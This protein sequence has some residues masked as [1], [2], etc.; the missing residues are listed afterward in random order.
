[1]GE[2]RIRMTQDF[3]RNSPSVFQFDKHG[4]EVFSVVAAEQNA[5]FNG[6]AVKAD[7]LLFV[8]EDVSSEYRVEEFN[9]LFAAEKADSAGT[10]VIQSSLGYNLFDD[11]NMDYKITDLDGKTA[12]V[13][14]AAAM[15]RD[16]G[17]IVVVSAGNEG[18]NRWRYV[19]PPADADGI[20]A[21]GAVNFE[22]QKAGFSSIGPTADGRIKPDVMALGQSTSVIT[23]NGTL[24]SASGTSLA[25]PLVT[26]LVAGLLQAYPKLRPAEIIQAVKLSASLSAAPNNQMGYGL[27]HYVAVKNYLES[28]QSGDDVYVYPNPT[29]GTLTVAFKKLPESSVALQIFD[30]L[31]KVVSAPTVLLNWLNNP[32]ELPVSSLGPGTYFLQVRTGA[33]NKTFRFVKL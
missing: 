11:P 2:G 16:R 6:G 30:S 12:V 19:T 4:T 23:S 33:L 8:T 9:W 28:N 22:F 21:V 25:A 7:Y 31:G 20:L 3:V 24:G 10:D 26:S 15:A 32:L 17:I 18:S 5:L 14:R 29:G 1:V 13:T 27:P